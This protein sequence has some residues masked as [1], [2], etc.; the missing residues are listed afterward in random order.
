[1]EL[2]IWPLLF[3][4]LCDNTTPVQIPTSTFV[5]FMIQVA[6]LSQSTFRNTN[7][8][9]T[10]QYT[11]SPQPPPSSSLQ[12]QSTND[13]GGATTVSPM[14]RVFNLFNNTNNAISAANQT[15]E[16]L[17][18]MARYR[19]SARK[20]IQHYTL[21]STNSVEYKISDIVMT[22]IFLLRSEKF[23]VVFK[24]LE[25]TFD[26]YTC[27]PNMT[28]SE[29]SAVLDAL[30]SLLEMPTSTMDVNT[31]DVMRS[32]FAKCFNSPVMRYAKIVLLQSVSLH[33]D[34][35]ITLDEL[36]AE[37]AEKIQTLI[38]QQYINGDTKIPCCE[39]QDFLD[40]LLRH[41]DPFSLP[42]MYYNAANTIF[43]T[44][45]ENYAV[46]NCK[47]NVEDYNNIFKV[48]TTLKGGINNNRGNSGG[49]GGNGGNNATSVNISSNNTI[50]DDDLNIYMGTHSSFTKRKKY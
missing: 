10:S 15:R 32:S 28:Q 50:D 42:R 30:R 27:R 37:R 3:P 49:G 36:I 18:D 38:P 39:D 47:F 22:M 23:H 7:A 6:R 8:A 2:V 25:S 24:L 48:M 5:D 12:Q 26:D 11:A 40:S 16:Q 14:R 29:I 13:S 35:R 46:A 33:R 9:L 1:M 45:M 17:I 31:I 43:Y 19:R 41:I 21:N 34:K 4:A 20:V 44:T